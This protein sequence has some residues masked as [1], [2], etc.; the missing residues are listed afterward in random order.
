MS[1]AGLF[2]TPPAE[3]GEAADIRRLPLQGRPVPAKRRERRLGQQLA[4]GLLF[5]VCLLSVAFGGG[6][7]PVLQ[8]LFAVMIGLAALADGGAALQRL[9]GAARRAFALGLVLGGYA[10]FQALPLPALKGGVPLA[11]PGTDILL[12]SLSLSPGDSLIAAIRITGYALFFAL[13]L[14][15]GRSARRAGRIAL[16]LFAAIAAQAAWAIASLQLTGGGPGALPGQPPRPALSGAATGSFAGHNALAA[17]LT[18][19]ML[20]GLALLTRSAAG[21]HALRRLALGAGLLLI[22]TALFATRSRMGLAAALA[23]AGLLLSL[24]RNRLGAGTA[25]AGIAS[26]GLIALLA[27]QSGFLDRIAAIGLDDES[28]LPLYAQ[29]LGMIA[30]HPLTGLGL[31]AFAQAYPPYH[32]PPVT[33]GFVWDRAHSSYLQGWAEAGLLFG[34]LPLLG[35]ALLGR[36]LWCRARRNA[37]GRSLALAA[38]S[39][40]LAMALHSTVDFPLEIPA[41]AYLLLALIALG[42]GPSHR[43]RTP[44]PPAKGTPPWT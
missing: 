26:L 20:L 27:M 41:N 36:A 1:K 29:L 10:L 17:H 28:R 4:L 42:L 14:Q 30:D 37:P 15:Q 2:A 3:L 7:R 34:S 21:R 19:G 5:A 13:M 6:A 35:G 39:A 31:G 24:R 43:R 22:L 16:A 40:L 18:M 32:A 12:N 9:Q 25:A 23:G 11:L 33:A 38:L 8:L 44:P